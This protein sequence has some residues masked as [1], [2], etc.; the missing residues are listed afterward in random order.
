MKDRLIIDCINCFPDIKETIKEY[1]KTHEITVNYLDKK[2]KRDRLPMSLSGK[3]DYIC[4]NKSEE[5]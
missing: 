5:V 4:I 1:S 2:I 3:T